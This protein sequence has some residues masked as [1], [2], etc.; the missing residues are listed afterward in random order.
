MADTDSTC[1]F[2]GCTRAAVSRGYCLPCYKRLRRNG[3]LKKNEVIRECTVDGCNMPHKAR[4][5]CRNHYARYLYQEAGECSV[6]G[7]A[8]HVW[9]RGL[10]TAH[11]YYERV[12]AG[13]LCK[14]DGCGGPRHAWEYCRAH[15]RQAKA[16]NEPSDLF[17]CVRC[18]AK[19]N[20]GEPLPSGRRKPTDTVMCDSCRGWRRV[21]S[22]EMTV[23]EI[24]R[25]DGNECQ[26]CG[27]E[28]DLSIEWPDPQSPSVDHI[29]PGA[30]GGTHKADNLAAVHLDCNLRKGIRIEPMREP[31]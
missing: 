18:G 16:G 14:V 29:I 8:R 1:S 24:V 26:I 17:P 6:T 25:R 15:Y 27:T 10:C 28:M 19:I 21:G 11:Y 22:P 7:C 5:L 4:G 3:S 13:D 23:E 9:T 2:D 12:E 20:L 30:L 31:A